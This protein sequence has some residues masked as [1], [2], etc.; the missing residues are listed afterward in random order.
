MGSEEDEQEKISDGPGMVME[1]PEPAEVKKQE[2]WVA[3]VEPVQFIPPPKVQAPVPVQVPKVEVPAPKVVRNEVPVQ[4]VV[5]KRKEAEKPRPQDKPKEQ[6]PVVERIEPVREGVSIVDP[7]RAPAPGAV[8]P[9]PVSGDKS[10]DAF[11]MEGLL[12]EIDASS[13]KFHRLEG[14]DRKDTKNFMEMFHK[15]FQDRPLLSEFYPTSV[16]KE[17]ANTSKLSILPQSRMIDESVISKMDLDTLFFIFYYSKVTYEKY[18][19]AKEL[20][21]RDW[22]YNK[23]F[24]AWFKRHEP[25]IRTT[26]E[27]EVGNF[28]IF[29]FDDTF[30]VKK[31]NNFTFEYKHLEDEV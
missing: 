6:A 14:E 8:K 28:L 22:R 5:E 11:N 24:F 12:Q 3:P 20:K 25:P 7:V 16:K 30:R 27:Y 4:V 15:S 26:E 10:G 21:K 13:T 2:P 19:A 17:S 1:K 18:L 29:D 31:R 9:E 23:K